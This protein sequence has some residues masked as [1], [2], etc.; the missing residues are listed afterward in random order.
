MRAASALAVSLL[1]GR[2]AAAQAPAA[3]PPAD[4]VLVGGKVF[5]A[6]PARPWAEGLAITGDRVTAVGTAAEVRAAAGP[7]T[8]IIE[9][10]GRVV[11]PGF[12]DAHMHVRPGLGPFVDM[13]LGSNDPHLAD[14]LRVLATEKGR[15]PAG[16]WLR[17]EIGARVLDDPAATRKTLDEA[18]PSHPVL[19]EAWTGHGAV[20]NTAALRDLGVALDEPD[21]PGGW[22]ERI[23]G[24]RQLSGVAHEY[25]KFRLIRR[26]AERVPA[27]DAVAAVRG[28][29]QTAL[30]L[31]IT[32]A[33]NVSLALPA[34]RM[35]ALLREAGAPLR[36][37]VV[38]FPFEPPSALDTVEGSGREETDGVVVWGRKWILD[39]TPIERL[40]AMR[41]PY[42]DR[43]AWTGRLNFTP[44]EIRAAIERARRDREPL[45]LHVVGDAALEL[46]LSAME[47]SGG[48]EVWRPLR[49]R[50]EHA[51][52]LAPDLVAR[53]AALGV[54]V[55]VNP[56]H[57]MFPEVMAARFGPE[58]LA[59]YQ[60][61]RS[62]LAAGVPL[63]IGSDGPPSPFLNILFAAVHPTNP[64]EALSREQAVEAYTRGSAWAEFGEKEKGT[65]APGMLADLA[66]LSQDIFTVEPGRLPETASV[67]TVIG[68]RLV[69]DAETTSL[70][71]SPR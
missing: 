3:P 61:M 21:P 59:T 33:Q 50:F 10:R 1:A 37:R 28:Y 42:A 44:V 63:A 41:R 16:T 69:Y 18:A 52:G 8:R 47:A 38:R 58:R 17:G 57:H 49:P 71:R 68:G 9:L 11:V 66:V 46:A 54:A 34:P 25:A 22:F 70:E 23:R 4:V 15:A 53:A 26:F 6:D 19:L 13:A 36:W 14:V 2:L 35:A 39:G 27:A 45:L 51:D 30:R 48:A 12:N 55:V 43:P 40:A 31:G 20:V 60:P 5:T 65:L 67:L 56:S 29:V 24:S 62:L 7:G 32:S 64:R